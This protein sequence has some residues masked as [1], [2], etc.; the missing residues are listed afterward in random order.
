M[1]AFALLAFMLQGLAVQTHIHVPLQPLAAKA[2]S[3]PEPAP[4]KAQDPIDQC[5]LCQ[6]VAHAGIFVSPSASA[7]AVSLAFALAVFAPLPALPSHSAPA[8]GWRSRAPPRR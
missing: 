1:T 5:R 6:E 8:F 3:L 2:A 4:L 7:A